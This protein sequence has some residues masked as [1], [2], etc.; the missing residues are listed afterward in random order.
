M[1]CNGGPPDDSILSCTEG[2]R[3]WP[4]V[5]DDD[6]D[7]CFETFDELVDGNDNVGGIETVAEW[8]ELVDFVWSV[9]GSICISVQNCQLYVY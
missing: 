8:I 5:D 1:D 3:S 6:D 7:D 4:N 9:G 2:C